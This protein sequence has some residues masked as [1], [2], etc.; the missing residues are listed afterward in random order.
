ME[1]EPPKD[2][3]WF[4]RG[5]VLFSFVALVIAA[6][7][8]SFSKYF[9]RSDSSKADT[10]QVVDK[11]ANAL[12]IA[13]QFF[14][15]QK[16]GKLV[17]N[18]IAWRGD[19]AMGDGS[20]ANLDLTKGMF[21]AGDHVKFGF[22]MA[23]TATV[24]SW[25]ILEYGNNMKLVNELENAQESL[26]WIT[27]FLIN[28]HP[29]DNVLYIQ[30]GDPKL[31]HTCWERPE[32]MTGK[33]PLTQVNAT[34]PGTDVAAETAAAMAAASLVF[35]SIDSAYSKT[36]LKHARQLF[37]FADTYRGL[38][39]ISIP[40]V[41]EFYNSTGFGDELLWAAAWL[42]HATRDKSYLRYV[43]TNGDVFANWG[44]SS[45]FSWENKL[46][47]VQVLLSRVNFFGTEED[48]S[49]EES[50]SLQLYRQTA[51]T[52]LCGLLPESPT[53]TSQRTPD[54]LVWVNQWNPLQYSVASSFLAVV[55]SDYMLSSQTSNLYCSGELYEPTELRNFAV[56]QLDYILGNN[57]TEMSYL[58]GYGSRYPQ[59]VHHRG[60]SIPV[61]DN[62]NCSDGFKWLHTREP[63]PN[64]A[65]GALVG[66]PSLSDT[67]MDFRNNISQSE[68]TTYNSALIVGLISGLITSSSQVESFVKN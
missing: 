48:I 14:D 49:T 30:V 11:Y 28:A 65:V 32:V 22:P 8:F 58:V 5:L 38:Y 54:G 55:Y 2:K 37:T 52:F 45:W 62:S 50:L 1:K 61:D 68:T 67:Y 42:Y 66:G 39:S 7:L 41:Q 46:A 20:E 57:P 34:Y 51:E 12:I 59:Q 44:N 18:K 6:V 64:V 47:G 31:D 56:S 60:A 43:A 19:S 35:K 29:S 17:N 26:K 3:R 63:N 27:D 53:A 4:W 23:F 33:R 21:D 36:L 10:H 13:M 24:L 15:V 25:S 9:H 40:G 16:S